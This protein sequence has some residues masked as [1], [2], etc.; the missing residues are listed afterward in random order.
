MVEL[1]RDPEQSRCTVARPA[2]EAA[3]RLEVLPARLE[4]HCPHRLHFALL[5]AHLIAQVGQVAVVRASGQTAA[6][7]G[8]N[9]LLMHWQTH[10]EQQLEKRFR[11]RFSSSS[12]RCIRLTSSRSRSCSVS[13][14]V[15]P[16]DFMKLWP[17][18]LGGRHGFPP[19]PGF[20]HGPPPFGRPPA[21]TGP[22]SALRARF[23]FS[24]TIRS[25]SAR[26]VCFCAGDVLYRSSLSTWYR[27]A[28]L[29]LMI[30]SSVRPV[31][32]W[33]EALRIGAPPPPAPTPP[34]ERPIGT[35]LRRS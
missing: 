9:V 27:F 13:L 4:L 31:T 2:P 32:I 14:F 20:P 15:Q 16:I 3:P 24:A 7:D 17:T 33:P 23:S 18:F 10:R 22:S 21:G 35:G 8:S 34:R 6:R 28:S 29:K 11:K 5:L 26:Y 1:N 19:G 30:G 12:W 25:S